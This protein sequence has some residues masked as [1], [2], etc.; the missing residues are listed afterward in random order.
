MKKE[1]EEKFNPLIECKFLFLNFNLF[2]LTIQVT[3]PRFWYFAISRCT[4]E[5]D[6]FY[7]EMDMHLTN[8][9]H[10]KSAEVNLK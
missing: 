6:S 2:L 4:E 7:V 9:H 1:E 10:G 5:K 8:I 3:R